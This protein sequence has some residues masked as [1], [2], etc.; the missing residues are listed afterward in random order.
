MDSRLL[1]QLDIVKKKGPRQQHQLFCVSKVGAAN[2]QLNLLHPRTLFL[3]K[4]G[5]Q[6]NNC[7]ARRLQ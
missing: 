6:T 5:G 7:G 1:Y 4:D 3:S 2:H